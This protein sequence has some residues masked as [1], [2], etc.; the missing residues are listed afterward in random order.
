MWTA[1]FSSAMAN[2][3]CK[4]VLTT[5][6]LSRSTKEDVLADLRFQIVTVR[7][8]AE[9]D[10]AEAARLDAEQVIAKALE[11]ECKD[12]KDRLQAISE[13]FAQRERE[14]AKVVSNL[15]DL[16]GKLLRQLQELEQR[17]SSAKLELRKL[18]DQNVL[19]QDKVAAN[20]AEILL[21]EQEIHKSFQQASLVAAHAEQQQREAFLVLEAQLAEMQKDCVAAEQQATDA[22]ATALLWKA[23]CQDRDTYAKGKEQTA[24][25]EQRSVE[26]LPL[27]RQE[28]A[29]AAERAEKDVVLTERHLRLAK[30]APF[31]AAFVASPLCFVLHESWKLMMM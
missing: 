12:L 23:L 9:A 28:L 11:T 17:D 5:Q 13:E 16:K 26:D 24:D 27:R 19:L 7:L 4:K 2:L 6:G 30:W 18:E 22:L 10:L 14:A 25:E 15:A 3:A 20:E 8:A 1:D 21:S 29:S 31:C